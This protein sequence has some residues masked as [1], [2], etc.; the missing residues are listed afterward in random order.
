MTE[1]ERGQGEDIRNKKEGKPNQP[2]YKRKG[3]LTIP[4]D[5]KINQIFISRKLALWLHAVHLVSCQTKLLHIPHADGYE[6][7]I[8]VM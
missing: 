6:F 1:T 7:D 2:N 8:D 4:L 3:K 5:I